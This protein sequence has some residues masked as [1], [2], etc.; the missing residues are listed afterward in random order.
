MRGASGS[1][2]GALA[3]IA[4]VWGACAPAWALEPGVHVDPGSP[5]GKEYAL[6]LSQARGLGATPSSSESAH[7]GSLFGAGI[8]PPGGS[9]PKGGATP[10]TGASGATGSASAPAEA[11]ESLARA[12]DVRSSEGSGDGSILALVGGG[13]VIL[14]LGAFGGTVL[15][16][17]RR[18]G[19][20]A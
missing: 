15:R 6:P 8:K 2:G 17:A 4:L 11:T 7:E 1:I 16:R 9:S 5:A 12:A 18:P 13:I 3:V 20:A 19:P 14:V 10:R